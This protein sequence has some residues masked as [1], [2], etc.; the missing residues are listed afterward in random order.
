MNKASLTDAI[1]YKGNIKVS[2]ATAAGKIIS[3]KTYHN[4][5]TKKLSKFLCHCLAGDYAAI[6]NM[7]PFKIGLFHVDEKAITPKD[8]E[9][10][11]NK[12]NYMK[13][14]TPIYISINKVADVTSKLSESGDTIENYSTILHFLVPYSYITGSG[15]GNKINEMCLYSKS[16][17]QPKGASAD[18][19]DY[20]AY[21]LLKDKSGEN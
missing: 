7:R 20:S 5:G 21:F 1:R 10:E 16:T 13:V 14:L 15:A 8:F 3:S 18:Y 12:N 6:D 19:T 2:T 4:S 9:N 11:A 17:T